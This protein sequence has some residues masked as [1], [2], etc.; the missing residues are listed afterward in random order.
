MHTFSYAQMYILQ[1]M[2]RLSCGTCSQYIRFS[3]S[4]KQKL[5]PRKQNTEMAHKKT[6]LFEKR[7]EFCSID[8]VNSAPSARRAVFTCLKDRRRPARALRRLAGCPCN[9]RLRRKET[10]SSLY[11]LFYLA[12]FLS[13]YCSAWNSLLLRSHC[14]WSSICR[15]SSWNSAP[16]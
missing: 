2:H 14:S 12:S 15:P 13:P 1:S 4:T 6:L 11:A 7:A 5:P 3:P 16:A 10:A 8:K 9:C